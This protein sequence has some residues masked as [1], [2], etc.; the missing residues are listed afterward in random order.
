MKITHAAIKRLGACW[1]ENDWREAFGDLTEVDV[2]ATNA[3]K[4]ANN[5]NWYWLA[6][7]LFTRTDNEKYHHLIGR[8]SETYY[9]ARQSIYDQHPYPEGLRY[10]DRLDAAPDIYQARQEALKFARAEYDRAY[11]DAFFVVYNDDREMVD[12]VIEWASSDSDEQSPRNIGQYQYG[13]DP[14]WRD[15]FVI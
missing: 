14:S 4:Y 9:Q 3:F 10:R 7:E 8:A 6:G 12:K 1:D 5:I 2:T 13:R 15:D 11:A